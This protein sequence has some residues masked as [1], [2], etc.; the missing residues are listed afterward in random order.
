MSCSAEFIPYQA[1]FTPHEVCFRAGLWCGALSRGRRNLLG[2]CGGGLEEISA[3][4]L[5][6]NDG[7]LRSLF[8]FGTLL[9]VNIK[10][11]DFMSFEK[12]PTTPSP[13]PKEGTPTPEGVKNQE[14]FE[15]QT[16][17]SEH[18]ASVLNPENKS[19]L[20]ECQ[21]WG[22]RLPIKFTKVFMQFRSSIELSA[23]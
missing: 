11:N 18:A 8:E 13:E 2:R 20:G 16:E 3:P 23:S 14:E 17:A 6:G 12:T 19:F 15:E 21:R 5:L 10:Y 9:S 1:E 7:L 4:F 22:Q